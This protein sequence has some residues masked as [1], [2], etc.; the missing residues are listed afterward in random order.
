MFIFLF[1]LIARKTSDLGPR[2]LIPCVVG[3]RG[4][5]PCRANISWPT[6]QG[7][8]IGQE[9]A[10]P[11]APS[12]R[13]ALLSSP[14]DSAM[15][16][17]Q[18]PWEVGWDPLVSSQINGRRRRLVWLTLQP[19]TLPAPDSYCCCSGIFVEEFIACQIFIVA[20]PSKWCHCFQKQHICLWLYL[21]LPCYKTNV[22]VVA[23]WTRIGNCSCLKLMTGL[24][25]G[26]EWLW[27]CLSVIV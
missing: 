15:D 9:P 2:F 16:S 5:C 18:T 24:G 13:G 17:A 1:Q 26:F 25:L 22:S 3:A 14:I 27:N 19:K 11:P 23:Q 12:I 20:L 4:W 8:L 7:R 10:L 21:C 6:L